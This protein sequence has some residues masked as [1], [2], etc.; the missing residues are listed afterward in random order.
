MS[1]VQINQIGIQL[2]NIFQK[3]HSIGYVFNDLKADNLCIGD[4]GET[5]PKLIK[6]IDFGLCSR[7]LDHNGNH[8]K[9]LESSF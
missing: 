9:D 2:L 6:I 1:K 4:Y 8:V 3:L 5:N 7:Y